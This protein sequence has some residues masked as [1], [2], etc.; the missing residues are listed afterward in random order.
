MFIKFV[1]YSV[2]DYDSGVGGGG[3]GCNRGGG[4]GGELF[5]IGFGSLI[6]L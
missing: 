6:T 2:L 5:L 4:E 3:Y 1:I